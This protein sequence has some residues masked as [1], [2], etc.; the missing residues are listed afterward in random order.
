MSDLIPGLTVPPEA[1]EDEYILAMM[2]QSARA[3]GLKACRRFAYL[4]MYGGR[5]GE[6]DQAVACCSVGV[7]A[8]D[9]AYE[10]STDVGEIING[11]DGVNTPYESRGYA[12]GVAYQVAMNDG[13]EP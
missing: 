12:I 3:R 11:N 2:L 5:T 7:L 6:I 9:C 1:D 4:D 13:V 10:Y 8:A